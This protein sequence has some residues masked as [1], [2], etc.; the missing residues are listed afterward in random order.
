M[1]EIGL[2]P[3]YDKFDPCSGRDRFDDLRRITAVR[4]TFDDGSY[5]EQIVDPT[6]AVV[7]VRLNRAVV[8][9]SITMTVL[10]TTEPGVPE[11]DHTAVSEVV[12][13]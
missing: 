1:R 5:V 13:G 11:L 3:G 4:W 12:V 7:T 8:T 9:S 2:L 6:P 10:S